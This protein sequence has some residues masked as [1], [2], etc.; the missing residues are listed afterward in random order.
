MREYQE[1]ELRSF[2]QRPS[3]L[4]L[5]LYLAALALLPW[6]WFPPFPWLHEHAQWSDVLFFGTAVAWVWECWRCRRRPVLGGLHVALA[7][8]LGAAVLSGLMAPPEGRA[9]WKLLGLAE[10]VSL[11][12][13]TEDLASRPGVVPLIARVVAVSALATA[14]AALAGLLLFYGGLATPLVGGYGDLVPSEKYARV[15]AGLYHPNLLASYCIFAAAVVARPDARLPRWLGRGARVAL[16]GTVALTF[17][18]A[19]LGFVAAAALRTARTR[20]QRLA[21]GI[22]I[23]ACVALVVFLTA[24]NVVLDPSRPLAVTLDTGEASPRWQAFTSSLRTVADRPLW[25]CGPGAHPGWCR[26]GPFDA[27]LTPLNIAAT[28]GLPAL[29]AFAGIVACLWRR[30]GRPPD[31]S[32][33][34]GLAGLA[35]DALASDV[36]DFRHVWVLFGLAAA[37]PPRK[38]NVPVVNQP[39]S[40]PSSPR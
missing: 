28:L 10:L 5:A 22:Y 14:A 29:A 6:S 33:W 27:H 13:L 20:C 37:P 8:Y 19:I 34:G 21:A 24:E 4:T 12:F 25:G 32:T 38:L 16:G 2:P 15:Q 11:T 9:G 35:L 30:R 40:F 17:S 23:A 36:E 7:L 31:R 18:R 3:R 26:G 39:R 1:S